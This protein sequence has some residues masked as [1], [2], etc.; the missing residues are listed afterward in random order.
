MA[1]I[2]TGA[3]M[4]TELGEQDAARELGGAVKGALAAGARTPDVGGTATTLEV[5][6]A[7]ASRI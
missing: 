6:Q 1:A 3:L 7:I 2:L 5:A 4:F